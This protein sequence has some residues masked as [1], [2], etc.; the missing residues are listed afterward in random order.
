[1][2]YGYDLKLMTAEEDTNSQR[3]VFLFFLI[4]SIPSGVGHSNAL[5][6]TWSVLCILLFQVC[7]VFIRHPVH[8]LSISFLPSNWSF[9]F[10][11]VLVCHLDRVFIFSSWYMTQPSH[12]CFSDF[13]WSLNYTCFSFNLPLLPRPLRHVVVVPV[14]SPSCVAEW[15]SLDKD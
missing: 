2:F 6:P 14:K 11:Q 9:S 15:A 12:S 5:P 8:F 4:A 10:Y 1:M 13:I 7:L 3:A